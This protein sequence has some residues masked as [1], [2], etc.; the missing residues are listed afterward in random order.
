MK[1]ICSPQGI[2]DCKQPKNGM[3]DINKAGFKEVLF[4]TN[5]GIDRIAPDRLGEAI[6]ERGLLTTVCKVLPET[7]L[8][9]SFGDCE[10]FILE[11]LAGEKG[12]LELWRENKAYYLSRYEEIK[13]MING[14]RMPQMLLQNL[15]GEI[16]GHYVRGVCS[17]A[18]EVSR[19]IDDLNEAVGEEVFG[20][21]VDIGALNLCGQNPY[22]FMHTLGSRVK[23]VIVRENDGYHDYAQ[24]PFTS[25]AKGCSQ[26]DWLNI[27]RGLREIGFDGALIMEF[28]DTASAFSP[29]LRTQVLSLAKNIADY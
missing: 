22:E 28:K 27:F 24:L 16:S 3:I 6:V 10:V 7:K 15:T 2:V 18:N 17:D 11:P 13:A 26:T 19:W 21:C 12:K 5:L 4:D 23:A 8:N 9:V 20:F 14:D 25:V 1:I 29:L